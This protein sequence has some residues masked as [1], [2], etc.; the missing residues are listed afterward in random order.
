MDRL[1]LELIVQIAG[2][3][4]PRHKGKLTRPKLATV[5]RSWQ[6]AIESHTFQSLCMSH[7]ELPEFRAAF[8]DNAPRQ[9]FLREL[10]W[11]IVLPPYESIYENDRDRALNSKVFT[12]GVAGLLQELSTWPSEGRTLALSLGTC[13][14]IQCTKRKPHRPCPRNHSPS[15]GRRCED[16]RY[17]CTY[18]HLDKL[19]AAPVDVVTSLNVC[20][21]P[22]SLDPASLFLLAGAAFPR[23]GHVRLWYKDTFFYHGLR[24]AQLGAFAAAVARFE[25]PAEDVEIH[26]DVSDVDQRARLPD[27]SSEV[28]TCSA[29]REMLRRNS[30]IRR[31]RYTG[32]VDASLFWDPHSLSL[33]QGD[34]DEWKNVRELDI[35][36][37]DY[38]L[39]G[40][41]LFKGLRVPHHHCQQ[42]D[43]EEDEAPLPPEH[44][45]VS[46]FPIGYNYNQ[47]QE[48]DDEHDHVMRILHSGREQQE[49]EADSTN[50]ESPPTNLRSKPRDKT[51]FRTIPRSTIILPLLSSLARRIAH[52]PSLRRITLRPDSDS[53]GG[54][55]FFHFAY[56]AGGEKSKSSRMDKYIISAQNK[57]NPESRARVFLHVK[58]GWEP[59]SGTMELLRGVGGGRM[60]L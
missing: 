7:H 35:R 2:H 1:P 26:M 37:H 31:L 19:P 42:E 44:P 46:L 57:G 55:V 18:L 11:D 34:N 49:E 9:S 15:Y 24:R 8:R 38:T 4:D 52:T 40:Q 13:K 53:D 28:T 50:E 33:S 23:L 43:E 10:R 20:T 47:N 25:T 6:Y 39:S 21:H 59:D 29:L 48:M 60:R 5:S 36:F 54:G 22:R 16:R 56:L 45:S 3:I 17:I 27:L 12:D 58:G 32:P 30:H 14:P 51:P 41:W